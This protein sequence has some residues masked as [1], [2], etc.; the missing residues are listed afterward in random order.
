MMSKPLVSVILPVF[1]GEPH[2]AEAIQSVINQT[3]SAVELI[4]VDDGS[5]DRSCEIVRSF[6]PADIAIKLLSQANAGVSATRNRGIAAARGDL[7]AFLDQDDHWADNTLQAHVTFHQQHPDTA[8]T[9]G[10]QVCFLDGI[11]QP[12][13]WF[14]LQKLDVPHTGYL[15]GTLMVKR[16]LFEQIGVFDTQYPISSDADWFARARDAR[17]LMHILPQTLLYRRI[18]AG[19]QSRHSQQI[20]GELTRLLRASIKRKRDT[21]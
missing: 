1:N 6:S 12:P 13:A 19:N 8:Y 2:L 14:Q 15:P 21:Q 5:T 3:W 4:V 10:Q 18:H 17:V 16:H 11:E 9:L 7:V 20:Q